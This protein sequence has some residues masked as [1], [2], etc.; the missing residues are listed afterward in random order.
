MNIRRN[1]FMVVSTGLALLLM[2]ASPNLLQAKSGLAKLRATVRPVE[3]EIFID[4]Q[5]MGDAT[6][7]GTVTVPDIGPGDHKVE[8]RNWGFTPQS[9]NL[10]LAERPSLKRGWS[11]FR[12]QC[13]DRWGKSM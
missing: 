1:E 8:V 11:R 7:D 13:R 3:S 5:H 10:R 6:W 9:Y 4:G 2:V 12:G